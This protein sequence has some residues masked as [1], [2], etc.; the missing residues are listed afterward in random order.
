MPWVLRYVRRRRAS[1]GAPA[2]DFAK[3][4]V[5]DFA[6]GTAGAVASRCE[7]YWIHREF[8]WGLIGGFMG[9]FMDSMEIQA[10]SGS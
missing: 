5:Q 1:P 3:G 9:I 6:V 4:A 2:G 7:E 10:S 8:H